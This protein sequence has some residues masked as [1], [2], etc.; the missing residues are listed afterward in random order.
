MEARYLAY[1]LVLLLVVTLALVVTM[2]RGRWKAHSAARNRHET[3]EADMAQTRREL[4]KQ[5]LEG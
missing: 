3:D 2:L 4:L 5:S 1:A